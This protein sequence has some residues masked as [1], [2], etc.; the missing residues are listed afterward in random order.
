[1][2]ISI[3]VSRPAYSFPAEKLV[4]FP[5]KEVPALV[6]RALVATIACFPFTFK[7][8][9]PFSSSGSSPTLSDPPFS[10][11]PK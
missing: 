6:Y 3:A 4:P 5:K 8:Y 1:M 7:R 9:A 11:Y 2:L 10:K